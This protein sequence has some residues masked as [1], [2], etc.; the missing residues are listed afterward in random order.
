MRRQLR[1]PTVLVL[2][3]L[4]WAAAHW[5]AHRTAGG[6]A[7]AGHGSEPHAAQPP[8]ALDLGYLTTSLALCLGLSLLL[9]AGAA[10]D[11][12]GRTRLGRSLWLFGAVPVLGLLGEVLVASGWTV[13]GAGSTLAALAPLTLVVLAVQVTVALVAMRVARGLFGLA[14]QLARAAGTP[15]SPLPHADRRAFPPS[16]SDRVPTC[17]LTLGGG[18]R[19]PPAPLPAC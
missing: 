15:R 19:A 2:G 1:A 5:V 7:P 4:A 13:E 9:A 12:H 11:S 10:L 16:R 6:G 14:E 17:R 3:G 18:Q 8:G